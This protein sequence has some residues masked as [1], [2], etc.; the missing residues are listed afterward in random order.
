MVF[1]YDI[2]DNTIQLC[3]ITV[4]IYTPGVSYYNIDICVGIQYAATPVGQETLTSLPGIDM[5]LW[6]KHKIL[7][8]KTKPIQI[9]G[10]LFCGILFCGIPGWGIT[11]TSC[12][13]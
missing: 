10:I 6:R 4:C 8:L 7:F 5:N 11:V 12:E 2:G 3:D 9:V 1:M 13:R